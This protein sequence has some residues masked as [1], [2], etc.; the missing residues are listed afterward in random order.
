M[1]RGKIETFLRDTADIHRD[2]PPRRGTVIVY[3]DEKGYHVGR[4]VRQ[5]NL[6]EDGIVWR[7]QEGMRMK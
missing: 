2:L 7:C 1:S 3:T 5:T 4:H 6:L